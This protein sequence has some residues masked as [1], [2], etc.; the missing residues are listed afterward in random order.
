MTATEAIAP[1]VVRRP[2]GGRQV[3]RRRRW[4]RT[5]RNQRRTRPS[6][7][8]SRTGGRQAAR[9]HPCLRH[10]FLLQRTAREQ[11]RSAAGPA[12][13]RPL[14]ARPDEPYA[15][16]P[17]PPAVGTGSYPMPF[18]QSARRAQASGYEGRA[19][20]SS[21][22]GMNGA[23]RAARVR[24]L[25]RRPAVSESGAEKFP[26]PERD[27]AARHRPV[28]SATA[29]RAV[30][31]WTQQ[32]DQGVDDSTKPADDHPPTYVDRP[33]SPSRVT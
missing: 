17:R 19:G 22:A 24:Q 27:G 13:R 2:A 33:C 4:H 8:R 10:A 30:S 9:G 5:R 25:R 29:S 16:E 7:R 6:R 14:R 26:L 15:D 21:L 12:A 1:Y 11:H 3:R 23:G 31:G 32:A 28:G 18:T 20:R